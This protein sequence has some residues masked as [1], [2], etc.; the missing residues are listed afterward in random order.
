MRHN[1]VVVSVNVKYIIIMLDGLFILRNNK[2]KLQFVFVDNLK[3]NFLFFLL[4]FSF[5]NY[6]GKQNR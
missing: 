1:R 3:I 5:I 4:I 2:N 6:N